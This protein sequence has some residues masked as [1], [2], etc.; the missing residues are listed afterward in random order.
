MAGLRP[1]LR[2]LKVRIPTELYLQLLRLKFL[3]NQPIGE[4]MTEALGAYFQA[5]DPEMLARIEREF[6]R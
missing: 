2:E 6:R 5:A 3:R 4:T 1:E